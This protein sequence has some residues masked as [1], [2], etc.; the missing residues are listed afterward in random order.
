MRADTASTDHG[1]A[2]G[3]VISIVKSFWPVSATL[4]V[5]PEVAGAAYFL[6]VTTR[7]EGGRFA[8][9]SPASSMTDF[10]SHTA[11]SPAAAPSPSLNVLSVNRPVASVKP[12]AVGPPDLYSKVTTTSGSGF[13]S[14]STRPFALYVLGR[15]SSHLSGLRPQPKTTKAHAAAPAIIQ[16]YAL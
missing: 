5:S 1:L 15:C 14:Q 12:T 7:K 13:P 10:V 8:S 9:M 3:P 4:A 16:A 2:L 6:G 11:Y